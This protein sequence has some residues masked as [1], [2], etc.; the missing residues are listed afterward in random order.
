MLIGL[1]ACGFVLRHIPTPLGGERR[2][3]GYNYPRV[4]FAS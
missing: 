4:S 3:G 1:L 2:Y